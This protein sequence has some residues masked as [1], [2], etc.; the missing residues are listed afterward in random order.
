[1][2]A[3]QTSV[4]EKWVTSTLTNLDVKVMQIIEAASKQRCWCWFSCCIVPFRHTSNPKE[5]CFHATF[6]ATQCGALTLRLGPKLGT[7]PKP[8]KTQMRC[9]ASMTEVWP[10]RPEGTL[11]TVTLCHALSWLAAV[12][13]QKSNQHI[14]NMPLPGK[15]KVSKFLVSLGTTM[16]LEYIR[17]LLAVFF[18]ITPFFRH[19]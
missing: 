1:M 8:P 2:T 4:A 12:L 10:L 3:R 9:C 14:E 16:F 11:L 18:S 13:S 17:A 6:H 19:S 15:P 5:R 7:R